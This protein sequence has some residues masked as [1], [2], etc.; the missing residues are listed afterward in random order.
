MKEPYNLFSVPC[1]SGV[2]YLIIE[3]ITRG[4]LAYH[5]DLAGLTTRLDD[6]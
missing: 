3:N 4:V 2:T 5:S 6:L 1:S